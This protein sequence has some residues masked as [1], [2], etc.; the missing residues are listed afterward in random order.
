MP[1]SVIYS[2]AEPDLESHN[3]DDSDS[4][5]ITGE[6]ISKI[7]D[8]KRLREIIREMQLERNTREFSS[9]AHLGDITNSPDSH[10]RK[11]EKKHQHRTKK[12]PRVENEPRSPAPRSDAEEDPDQVAHSDSTDDDIDLDGD[13]DKTKI[14][15]AG[16]LFVINWGLW[17]KGNTHIFEEAFDPAYDE[18]KHFETSATKIQGQLRDIE[19]LLPDGYQ[20]EKTKLGK[21]WVGRALD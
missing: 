12:R 9:R 20:G 17:V 16:H 18:K 1:P 8:P 14:K 13:D 15:R 2:D 21:T 3:S 7:K 11:R 19:K 4:G 10:K 5:T 6:D